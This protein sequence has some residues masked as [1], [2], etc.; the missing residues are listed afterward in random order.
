MVAGETAREVGRDLVMQSP[1][2]CGKDLGSD[3]KVNRRNHHKV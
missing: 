1:V 3:F 2:G